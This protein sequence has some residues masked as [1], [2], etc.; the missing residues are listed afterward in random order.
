[1]L[2]AALRVNV[3]CVVLTG[4][5]MYPGYSH[6]RKLTLGSTFEAIGAV[7]AGNMDE[8]ELRVIEQE[9]CPGCGNSG[10]CGGLEP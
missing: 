9:C 6:G 2:M 5:P 3:P 1:M 8:E 10:V 4:G 7:E